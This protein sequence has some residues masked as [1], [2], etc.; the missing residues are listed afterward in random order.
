MR[1]SSIRARCSARPRRPG[2]AAIVVFHNH[3]SGDPEPSSEDIA[4]TRRLIAAGVL[5]GIDVIDHVILGNVRY[6]SM[7]E[8]R[9]I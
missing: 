6:C 7:K 1:A 2:A 4:L 9:Y 3:P 8:E 5:M